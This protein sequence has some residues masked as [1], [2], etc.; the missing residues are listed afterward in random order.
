MIMYALSIL[1]SANHINCKKAWALLDSKKDS[2][3]KYVLNKSFVEQYFDVG[4][5][6]TPN[7]WMTLYA[8]LSERYCKN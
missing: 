4:K 3:G 7:K 1:G 5:V 8:L 6:G 2:E